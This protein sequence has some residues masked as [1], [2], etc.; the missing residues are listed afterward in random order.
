MINQPVALVTGASRGIGAAIAIKLALDG[1]F[2]ILNSRTADPNV[3]NKGV[4]S[5]KKAIVEAGGNAIVCRADISDPDERSSI[6]KMIDDDIGRIDLHINNAGIE[7][8]FD[9]MLEASTESFDKVFFTNVKGPFFLTQQIAKRMISGL[10]DGRVKTPRIIFITSV[11]ADMANAAGAE[12]CMSKAALSMAMRS[13]AARL[14]PEGI[15][16]Y[17]IRPGI[18]DTDMTIKHREGI[19]KRIANGEILT[20][21]SGQPEDIAKVACAIARGDF[22]YATGAIIDVG[23]GFGL[24]RL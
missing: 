5:V 3:T 4:F 12:Y 2:L 1:Y 10:K 8:P 17:E 23:G 7:P 24:S 13:Y 14:G 20:P 22:D 9:D 6:L 11:Q 15:N 16:V 19:K 21:R 18:I